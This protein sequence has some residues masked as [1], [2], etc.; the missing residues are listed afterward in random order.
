MQ[1]GSQYVWDME[2]W[3][4]C[5]AGYMVGIVWLVLVSIAR[6]RAGDSPADVQ[7]RG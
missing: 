3:A 7:V 1:Y 5:V 6:I 4:G 2:E